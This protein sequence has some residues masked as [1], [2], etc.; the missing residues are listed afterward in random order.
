MLIIVDHVSSLI[1]RVGSMLINSYTTNRE[2][3]LYL[4]VI[5]SSEKG[6][7]KEAQEGEEK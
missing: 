5:R 4:L 6:A 1:I 3:F 7:Q 2:I